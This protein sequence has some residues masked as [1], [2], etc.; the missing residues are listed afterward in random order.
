MDIGVAGMILLS[1]RFNT[2]RDWK[3]NLKN[4]TLSLLKEN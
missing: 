2:G 4:I 1:Y 3:V